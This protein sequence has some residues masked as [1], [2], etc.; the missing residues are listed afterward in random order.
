MIVR[1]LKRE[2]THRDK[3]K[4]AKDGTTYQVSR[5]SAEGSINQQVSPVYYLV[6]KG[7]HL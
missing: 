4:P 5:D 2:K 3:S 6:Q 7:A 1:D